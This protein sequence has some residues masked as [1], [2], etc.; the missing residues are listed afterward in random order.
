MPS[1]Y[2]ISYKDIENYTDSQ[3]SSVRTIAE[4]NA[5]KFSWIV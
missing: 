2:A 3:V 4:Q 5:D 1:E